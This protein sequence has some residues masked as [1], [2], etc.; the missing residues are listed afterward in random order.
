MG[1]YITT[2]SFID[3][4]TKNITFW[5]ALSSPLNQLQFK[6]PHPPKANSSF[7]TPL[8]LPLIFTMFRS[9]IANF[10]P[11]DGR[12]IKIYTLGI[13]KMWTKYFYHHFRSDC[14]NRKVPWL[15]YIGWFVSCFQLLLH[16]PG[17][18]K[19]RGSV[20]KVHSTGHPLKH[21]GTYCVRGHTWNLPNGVTGRGAGVRKHTKKSWVLNTAIW[22]MDLHFGE[23]K[24]PG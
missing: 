8:S 11:I 22:Q 4:V 3:A 5:A 12:R 15:N 17:V 19:G 20:F 6:S 9:A 18:S 1:A 16:V 10:L 2:T 24:M 23:G 14:M 7:L 21:G 13:R